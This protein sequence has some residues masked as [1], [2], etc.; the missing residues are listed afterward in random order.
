MIN[1]HI[2]LTLTYTLQKCNISKCCKRA[3]IFYYSFDGKYHV[4]HLRGEIVFEDRTSVI[5]ADAHRYIFFVKNV[6]QHHTDAYDM[7]IWGYMQPREQ[8]KRKWE[9]DKDNAQA[10]SV[11]ERA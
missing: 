5:R 7:V 11:E 4:R 10:K 3:K 6:L 9:R 1:V 2:T 8:K